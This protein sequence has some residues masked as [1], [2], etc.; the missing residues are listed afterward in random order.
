MAAAFCREHWTEHFSEVFDHRAAFSQALQDTL[1]WL[2]KAL[3]MPLV[4]AG[5]LLCLLPILV[6]LWFCGTGPAHVFAP[7]KCSL[8]GRATLE[9]APARQEAGVEAALL[10]GAPGTEPPART[11]NVHLSSII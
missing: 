11:V 5:H 9:E 3:L 4:L 8:W 7:H 6:Q 2:R 1:Q 10:P